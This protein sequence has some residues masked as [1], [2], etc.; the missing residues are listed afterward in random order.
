MDENLRAALPK[1]V[2]YLPRFAPT[3]LSGIR[4]AVVFTARRV[5]ES[6]CQDA[7]NLAP[8]ALLSRRT[9]RR[10][11]S[12]GFSYGA[13]VPFSIAF[14]VLAFLSALN[15]ITR[16]NLNGAQRSAGLLLFPIF[17]GIASNRCR[18][19]ARLEM[20]RLARYLHRDERRRRR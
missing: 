19:E 2:S 1:I 6:W 5:R 16:S 11:A 14:G 13:F 12:V 20:D 3:I 9:K 4:R 17:C 18:K 8:Y 15:A 7:R 10:L